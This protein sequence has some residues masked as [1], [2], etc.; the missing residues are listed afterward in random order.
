MVGQTKIT[1]LEKRDQAVPCRTAAIQLPG[2]LVYWRV[3]MKRGRVV[4]V[5]MV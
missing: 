4:R 2:H 3:M 1:L 5:R